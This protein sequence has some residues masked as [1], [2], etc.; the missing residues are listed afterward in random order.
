MIWFLLVALGLVYIVRRIVSGRSNTWLVNINAVTALLVLYPCCFIN[1]D[2][3]IAGYNVRHCAESGGRGWPLS[4]DYLETLGTPALP[5]LDAIREKLADVSAPAE[6]GGEWRTRWSGDYYVNVS[7]RAQADAVSAKLHAQLDAELSDWR[8]WTWR[9]ERIKR[10]VEQLHLAHWRART[11]PQQL[12]NAS[13]AA[14]D[15]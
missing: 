5:A 6:T 8:T 1:F 9:R 10:D 11:P 14:S 4:I 13:P 3:L 7:C 2:G 15:R 12:A